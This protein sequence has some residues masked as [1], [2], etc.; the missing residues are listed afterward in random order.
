LDA[1]MDGLVLLPLPRSLHRVRGAPQRRR[2]TLTLPSQDPCSTAQ[3]S[4]LGVSK[5]QYALE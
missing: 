2:P 1:V 4:V 5:E 3:R